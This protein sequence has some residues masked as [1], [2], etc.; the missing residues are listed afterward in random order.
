MPRPT[1]LPWQPH[2]DRARPR[3][4]RP[5]RAPGARDETS[6]GA[7]SRRF[8]APASD[9]AWRYSPGRTYASSSGDFLLTARTRPPARSIVPKT[10][11]G[12]RLR[13]AIAL[14]AATAAVAAGVGW[15]G[16]ERGTQPVIASGT[17]LGDAGAPLKG[18]T[19]ALYYPSA[20]SKPLRVG[21]AITDR[22]GRFVVKA[23]DRPAF[24]MGSTR[25]GGWLRLDLLA[26]HS[27]LT[28]HE[29]IRRRLVHGR[30]LGPPSRAGSTDLGVFVLAK[31]RPAVT[32]VVHSGS[33]E[34]PQ[35]WLY[36]RVV[37]EPGS[38]PRSGSGGGGAQVP[39]AG[40]TVVVRA[41]GRAASTVSAKDGSFQMRLPAG[42]FTV[43]EDIC[44]VN[45]P[46]TIE[47]GGAVRLTLEI[48]NAC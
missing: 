39:V 1:R 20:Q 28:L 3:L 21:A 18:V 27:S 34:A 9:K 29:V 30:W 44:G 14:A 22:S 45:R 19:V 24:H 46:V 10:S 41:G 8:A 11:R 37:R 42:V 43:S 4:E 25:P 26:G 36:G 16:D 33:T 13:R 31:G 40:D 47:S 6:Q 2:R 23:A 32:T 48:P 17:V 15:A 38:D 7:G 5:H 35:G 12:G